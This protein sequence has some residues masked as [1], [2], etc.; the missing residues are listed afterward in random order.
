VL[1]FSCADDIQKP[2][3]EQYSIW[4]LSSREKRNAT[5]TQQNLMGIWDRIFEG[6]TNPGSGRDV[7][8]Q[9]ISIEFKIDS[10]LIVR[11]NESTTQIAQ[12]Q[13]VNGD[14]DLF[15]HEAEPYVN[16]L[17]GRIMFCDDLVLFNDSYR[18][19]VDNYFRKRE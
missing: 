6:G 11:N 8:N 5:Q 13:I 4:E 17:G 1:I 16:Y 10:S 19:L 9:E 18:D 2:P 3:N 15:S 12:W 14:A 7:S